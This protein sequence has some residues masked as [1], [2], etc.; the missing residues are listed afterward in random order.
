MKAQMY[1]HAIFVEVLTRHSNC[2][3]TV[4]LYSFSTPFR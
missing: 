4:N 1:A 2:R 3:E